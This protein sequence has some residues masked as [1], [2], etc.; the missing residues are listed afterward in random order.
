VAHARDIA[1]GAIC[2]RVPAPRRADRIA[3]PGDFGT[4][5]II[6]VDTEEEFD[7]GK[8]L[9]RD[10]RS[11]GAIGALP[12]AAAR[13]ADWGC[14]LAFMVDHPV[15]ADPAAAEV[16]RTL[17]GQP[18]AA[19]G[20]QLHPW[21][22]PPF[23]EVV[24]PRNSFPGNLPM[25]LEAAKIDALTKAIETAFGQRPRAYRAGRYGIGPNTWRLLAERGYRLDSSV[26]AR[27]EY[28]GEGGPDFRAVGN[29]AFWAEPA[30]G[31]I[32]L[33]LTTVFTGRLSRFGSTLYGAAGHVPFARGALART[34]ALSRIALTPEGMPVSDALEAI[35]VAA[36]Q[37]ERLLAFSFHSP[38]VAPGHTPYVRDATDLAA[39][40]R[41]WEVVFTLLDHLGVAPVGLDAVIDAADATR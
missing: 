22:N 4:R 40:W 14:P 39:F 26:R 33:P 30:S 15:V 2:H 32:E 23:D 5:A 34:R 11:V 24:T 37:G 27:Y 3:W 7:W 12:A 6:F 8:P 17:L 1:L 29:G 10:N 16:I 9:S 18:G 25:A 31:L 41:W 19:I 20:A 38:S 13:F 36:G 28:R 21:V 35:R